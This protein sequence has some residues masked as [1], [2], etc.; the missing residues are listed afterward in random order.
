V[1]ERPRHTTIAGQ[2][3][4]RCVNAYLDSLSI[5]E[6][7]VIEM[8]L[9]AVAPEGWTSLQEVRRYEENVAVPGRQ[10]EAVELL[11]STMQRLWPATMTSGRLTQFGKRHADEVFMVLRH[12]S[13]AD[14]AETALKRVA[15]DP[16]TAR[17]T[18]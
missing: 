17:E 8:K 2:W 16:E 14:E 5:E 12:Y 3:E 9:A 18:L 13:W 4:R 1:I 7:S 11:K 6:R 15:E 10:A